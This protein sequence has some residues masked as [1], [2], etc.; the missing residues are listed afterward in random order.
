MTRGK[1]KTSSEVF[2]FLGREGELSLR[3]VKFCR[4]IFYNMIFELRYLT[5]NSC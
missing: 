4:M 1:E 5:A 2:L 3:K